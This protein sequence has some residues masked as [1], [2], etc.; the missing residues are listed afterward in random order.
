MLLIA[1]IA[2]GA[3]D[4]KNT[5]V[6]PVTYGNSSNHTPPP[7][8][9]NVPNRVMNDS[10]YTSLAPCYV[11]KMIK[12]YGPVP[13]FTK[14]HR[15][16]SR[17]ILSGYSIEDRDALYAKLDKVSESMRSALKNKYT[18]PDGPVISYGYDA[19]GSVDIGIYEKSSVDQKTI[20]E[21]YAIIARES[22]TQGIENVPVV[23]YSE[24][25][26]ELDLGRF[27]V[28]RP[29]IGGVQAGTPTGA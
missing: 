27:D 3:S 16:V 23:F 8:F 22:D 14:D 21:M 15:I 1:G 24:S 19:L 10:M 2:S 7:P 18:Y 6:V 20:D 11:E 5:R 26:P 12:T 9:G 28:L 13:V 29:G 4:D 25:M 17:G